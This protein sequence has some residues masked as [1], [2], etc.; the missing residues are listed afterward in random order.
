MS[1]IISDCK[2]YRYRLDRKVQDDGIVIAYFG[3]NPSTADATI[4]DQTVKK[5]I[6]FAK[7]NNGSRFIVGNVFAYRSTN[8]R[9]LSCRDPIGADNEKYLQEIINEADILVPCWGN[10]SK[11][12]RNLR[13][14]F[15]EVKSAILDSG[16]PVKIFGLTNSDCP[17]H[18]MML[19]YNTEL[20]DWY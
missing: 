18:P 13:Y 12:Q 9:G 2:N 1:A 17:R 14:K 6:G 10:I 3:I 8:V 4:D 5:W 15:D 20:V 19:G 7:I 11:V 16:K